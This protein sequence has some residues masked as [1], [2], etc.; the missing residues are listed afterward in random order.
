MTVDR[1]SDF[2]TFQLSF[3]RQAHHRLIG[4][5]G[6][7]FEFEFQ[8]KFKFKFKTKVQIESD[9]DIDV[10]P[11]PEARLL[12]PVVRLARMAQVVRDIV[13]LIQ[14]TA[15]ALQFEGLRRVFYGNSSGIHRAEHFWVLFLRFS[16]NPP[17]P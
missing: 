3:A 8:I 6:L 5:S 11:E 14:I 9:I 4:Y 15:V 10:E 1:L 7:E 13:V 16:P 2:V 17:N 12:V